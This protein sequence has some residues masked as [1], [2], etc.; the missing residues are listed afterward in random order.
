MK[1]ILPNVCTD[2]T[3]NALPPQDTGQ[4]HGHMETDIGEPV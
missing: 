2:K 1:R 4:G 3:R